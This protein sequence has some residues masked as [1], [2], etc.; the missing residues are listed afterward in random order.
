MLTIGFA[1]SRLF[2]GI[3][4][5]GS[6]AVI[7]VF[8]AVYL[9]AVLG[10]GLLVSTFT[11]TQQQA[12]LISFFLMMIFVLLGG[13]YTAVESMPHWAQ[14]ITT[15]NP[16]TYFIEVLRMVV[17]KGSGFAEIKE[18]LAIMFG[19]AVVLNGWAVVSY[20]KRV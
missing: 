20:R 18:H 6:F 12:M 9:L 14:L 10:L 7:Y 1:V 2:Y 3:I 19:F 5:L 4:P 11:A 17:L 16:V 13:L 8:A 15:V